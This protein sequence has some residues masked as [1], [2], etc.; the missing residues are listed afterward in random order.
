MVIRKKNRSFP[1]QVLASHM[2]DMR[3]S[4]LQGRLRTLFTAL[5][6]AYNVVYQLIAVV[7]DY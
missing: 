4:L 7:I 6:A 1:N 3:V 2:I 5:F